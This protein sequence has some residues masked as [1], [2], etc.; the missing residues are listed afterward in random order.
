MLEAA[1]NHPNL[2]SWVDFELRFIELIKRMRTALTKYGPILSICSMFVGRREPHNFGWWDD[3]TMGGGLLGAAGSHYIDA[4]TWLT[5]LKITAVSAQLHTE[6][7]KTRDNKPITSDDWFLLSLRF[8]DIPG[9]I[10]MKCLPHPNLRSTNSISIRCEQALIEF[11]V[12]YNRGIN[13]QFN[14]ISNNG[15]N[16]ECYVEPA[17]QEPLSDNVFSKGTALLGEAL[18][19][20]LTSEDPGSECKKEGAANF[21]D[22]VY[23]QAVMDAARIS[24]K[25]NGYL[26]LLGCQW[27]ITK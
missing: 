3:E 16:L 6:V 23:V 25:T 12:D 20:V 11:V 8:G 7:K 19:R 14:V 5:G 26:C 9:S 21:E 13:P 17:V 18:K 2:L 10:Y 4:L 27:H 22:G 1:R 15:R 24:N